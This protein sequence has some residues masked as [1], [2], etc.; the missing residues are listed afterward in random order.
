MSQL[1]STL[2]R[3]IDSSRYAETTYSKVPSSY[4]SYTSYGST[5]ATAYADS[6]KIGFKASYLPSPRYHHTGLS[7]T[8]G[9]DSSRLS[10]YP[11]SSI[12]LSPT[13]IRTQPRPASGGLSRG[14]CYTF[15]GTPSSP[16][17]Y[18]PTT[19]PLSRHKSISHS[20]LAQEF[21]GLHASDSAYPASSRG[22]QELGALQDL[23]QSAARSDYIRG[24]LQS[25]GRKSDQGSLPTSPL[26][27][28]QATLG[29][30]LPPLG[31]RCVS[32]PCEKSDGYCSS[33]DLMVSGTCWGW[34]TE[35][36]CSG[37]VV[38]AHWC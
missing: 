4:S 24:Y 6:D 14:T 20:D 32:Q 16:P 10:L 23:Y 11:D 2:K 12:C 26:G 1:S 34:G 38:H 28:S 25:H 35:L 8:S 37:Y 30:A 33:Q 13:Y 29:S 9:Y 3:Y 18:L 22:H 21:S 36:C 17:G 5:L 7:P 19:V 15:A 27:S 31:T